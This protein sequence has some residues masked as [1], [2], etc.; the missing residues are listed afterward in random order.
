MGKSRWVAQDGPLSGEVFAV[1]DGDDEC[2]IR[3]DDGRAAVYKKDFR[4]D[5]VLWF[6][7]IDPF[8]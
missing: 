7:G 5:A 8:A 3:L 2:F 4:C 1:E 6:V